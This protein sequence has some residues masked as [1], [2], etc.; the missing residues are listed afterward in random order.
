V[1]RVALALDGGAEAL[2]RQ[3]RAIAGGEVVAQM[4]RQGQTLKGQVHHAGLTGIALLRLERL[5]HRMPLQTQN[6]RGAS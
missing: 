6:L 3:W 5:G 4:E 1:V 2:R